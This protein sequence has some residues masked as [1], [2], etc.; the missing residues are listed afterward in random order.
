MEY[1]HIPVLLNEII[2]NLNIRPGY[3][4]IDCT[5]GGGGYS[6]AIAKYLGKENKLLAIDADEMAIKNFEKIKKEKNITNIIT[7]NGNFRNLK[8]IVDGKKYQNKT[9]INFDNIGGIVFDLGLSSAQLEDE[10]RGFSFQLDAPLDMAFGSENKEKTVKILNKYK[11]EDLIKIIRNFGEEKFAP[12]IAGAICEFRKTQPLATTKQ[13]VEIINNVVPEKYKHQKIHPATRTFQAI[14]MSTNEELDS[15]ERVL[16][17][18]L[19]ILAP[20]GRLVAVSFHSLEDRIVK[21]F[22]RTE[23]KDCLCPP[24]F[25]TCQCSHQAKLKMITK[26][27]VIATAEESNSN[28]RARSAKLRCA[29]KV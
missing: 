25:P 11:K 14:R 28:P 4:Y 20:S 22:I 12:R 6:L 3:D 23:S 17:Q 5:L 29:E 21:N 15:L 13:L 24:E 26:K 18:A 16:P 27:P 2:D 10:N 7:H 8:E 9:K 1:R 19:E